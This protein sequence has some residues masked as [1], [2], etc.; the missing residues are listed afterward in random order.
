MSDDVVTNLGVSE[1]AYL[2]SCF[3]SGDNA[4]L[5][6][7]ELKGTT[8]VGKEADGIE[9]ERYHLDPDSVMENTLASFYVQID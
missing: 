7:V 2:A 8:K 1:V 5:E 4:E 9:Y 6:T 3:A